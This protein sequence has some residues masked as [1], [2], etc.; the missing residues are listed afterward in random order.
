MPYCGICEGWYLREEELEHAEIGVHGGGIRVEGAVS[1]CSVCSD[2]DAKSRS[3]RGE[4]DQNNLLF[5]W[6]TTMCREC[7]Q[8]MDARQ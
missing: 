5:L 1:F 4:E 8:N 6:S 3:R 2:R 7:Q